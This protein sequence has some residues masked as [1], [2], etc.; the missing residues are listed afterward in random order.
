MHVCREPLTLYLRYELTW[1]YAA[2]V[3]AGEEVR[4]L[5][6]A[7]SAPWPADLPQHDFWLLDDS[8]LLV[9]HYDQ[10]HRWLGVEQVTDPA[11]IL[12]HTVAAQ[13]LARAQAV[14][15][16][17]YVASRAEL[18]RTCSARP[19]ERRSHRRTGL[20][21]PVLNPQRARLAAR[22]R[23][24]RAA[25]FPSGNAFAGRVGWAQSRVSKLETGA[26]LPTEGDCEAWVR[27]S[28][29]GPAVLSELLSL[30]GAARIEYVNARG[31]QRGRGLAVRQ[32]EQA[33][34][35]LETT[36]LCEYQP[37]MVPATPTQS[38]LPR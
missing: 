15:W 36:R 37:A 7:V 26:Q 6:L 38:D 4:I 19:P 32:A 28:G 10:A 3:A 18:R 33:R 14:P 12:R 30:L 22:L 8:E 11:A 25:A 17:F 5:P 34:L 27:V 31:V 23:Q 2:S 29:A 16:G 1:S 35:E 13:R 21:S 24:V 9:M 20:M